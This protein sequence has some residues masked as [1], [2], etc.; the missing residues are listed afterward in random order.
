MIEIEDFGAGSGVMKTNKRLVSAIA[1]TSLK[2][3]KYAQFNF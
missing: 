2:P 1:K 3:K